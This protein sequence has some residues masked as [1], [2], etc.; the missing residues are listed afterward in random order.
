MTAPITEK[1]RDMV[2]DML[3]AGKTY[4]Q[5]RT[6]TGRS[7]GSIRNMARQG[8]ERNER[9]DRLIREKWETESAGVIGTL[10]DIVAASV[11]KRGIELGL[12]PELRCQ[13]KPTDAQPRPCKPRGT[14]MQERTWAIENHKTDPEARML[15]TMIQHPGRLREDYAA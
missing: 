7:Y 14:S 13:P 12:D 6:A 10:L 2:M 1:Q 3:R 9:R 4:N 8:E 15:L 11:I 5:I